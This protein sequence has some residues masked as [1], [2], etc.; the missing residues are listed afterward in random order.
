MSKLIIVL[1]LIIGLVCLTIA[2]AAIEIAFGLWMD[3]VWGVGVLML[4]VDTILKKQ[5]EKKV[6]EAKR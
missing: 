4:F 2:L 3:V 6:G 5:E 1:Q